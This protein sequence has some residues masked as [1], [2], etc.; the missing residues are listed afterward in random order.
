M[1]D[2]DFSQ[3]ESQAADDDPNAEWDLLALRFLDGDESVE[4]RKLLSNP[5]FR[6]LLAVHSVDSA[7]LFEFSGWI[8]TLSPE[9]LDEAAIEPAR[10]EHRGSSLPRGRIQSLDRP[11][12]R[13][14]VLGAIAATI[15]AT[16]LAVFFF[17][18]G[19]FRNPG[20]ISAESRHAVNLCAVEDAVG[21]VTIGGQPADEFKSLGA[22]QNIRT[23]GALSSVRLVFSDSTALQL[24]GATSA[25][26]HEVNGQKFVYLDYGHVA[27]SVSPQPK[28]RPLMLHTSTAELEV[29]GTEFVVS[30]FSE[31]TQLRV[32]E[33]VVL[34]KP[35]G[36]G[37]ATPVKNGE[38]SEVRLAKILPPYETV[39]APSSW[40]ED[41]NDGLPDGWAQG[42]WVPDRAGE[43]TGGAVAAS[44]ISLSH[45]PGKGKDDHSISFDVRSNDR[46]ANGLLRV[47]DD[48]RLTY[49]IKM[50]RPQWYQVFLCIRAEPVQDG[51]WSWNY[52][53]QEGSSTSWETVE[54]GVWRVLDI[55]LN[56]FKR[57]IKGPPRKH[58]D[59]FELR[60]GEPPP[61]DGLVVWIMFTSQGEDRGMVIDD[62]AIGPE[63]AAG[64]Q[65]VNK[66]E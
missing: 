62:I 33:G 50:D 3:F 43:F 1:S 40:S 37:E 10:V 53:F 13:F 14:A 6:R 44:S 66:S 46:W 26:V 31:S 47:R 63:V 21:D 25:R 49:R 42:A 58:Y 20:A 28:D 9:A 11:I 8:E 39:S 60:T 48:T 38:S 22:G 30:A 17:S 2:R 32:S 29:V 64:G 35:R 19:D 51:E 52:E 7:N 4:I 18:N 16:L 12:S 36:S 45:G 61:K 59:P 15:A 56:K 65:S 27:A 5:R 23:M 34:M 54:P 24:A 41:F 57:Q 55:P